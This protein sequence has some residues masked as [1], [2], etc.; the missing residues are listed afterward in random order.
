MLS[1]QG[2]HKNYSQQQVLSNLDLEVKSNEMV[3]IMG[4]SGAGKSTLLAIMAGLQTPDRG[5]IRFN[6]EN[7]NDQSEEQLASFRLHNLGLVFQDFLLIPSLTVYDNIFIAAHPRK[8]ISK[9]DKHDRV[10]ALTER[11]GLKDKLHQRID[12][13]SGG[14]KQRVAIARSLV[15]QP[16]LVLADEPTGNLDADTAEDIMALFQTLHDELA[17]TF[18]IITH[19]DQVAA[20]TEKTY[21]LNNGVLQ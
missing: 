16:K 5:T 1:L 14:E 10:V 17:T 3:S 15:N 11:V 18:V 4:R 7:L 9:K 8:D 19:D 6:D 12:K 21:R 13:L 2:I 20:K